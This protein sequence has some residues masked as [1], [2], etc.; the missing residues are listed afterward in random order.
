V[1]PRRPWTVAATFTHIRRL[2]LT[3]ARTGAGDFRVDYNRRSDPR[4][5]PEPPNG[6]GGTSYYTEDLTDLR[7]TADQMAARPKAQP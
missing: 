7:Q 2:G 5:R 3:V 6:A 1:S 4:Y